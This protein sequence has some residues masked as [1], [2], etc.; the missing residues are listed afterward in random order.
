MYVCSVV[1]YTDYGQGPVL[2]NL[3]LDESE[4]KNVAALYPNVV[5][6]LLERLLTY[7]DPEEN[8]EPQQPFPPFAGEQY[9]CKACPQR[10]SLNDPTVEAWAPWLDLAQYKNLDVNKDVV[11]VTMVSLA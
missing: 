6:K 1:W 8:V 7:A 9:F 11:N 10:P 2:Y 3:Q 5:D 4:T